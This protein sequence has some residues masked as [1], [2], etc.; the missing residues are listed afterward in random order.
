M[1]HAD[2]FEHL[3][4]SD[5]VGKDAFAMWRDEQDGGRALVKASKFLHELLNVV[6]EEGDDEAT[7]GSGK[8]EI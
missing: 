7:A 8:D 2:L 5:T 3:Y 1:I 4:Q 6:E